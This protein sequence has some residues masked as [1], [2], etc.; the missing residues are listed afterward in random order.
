MDATKHHDAL[1][2]S[3]DLVNFADML[4]TLCCVNGSPDFA[5]TYDQ[6]F[7]VFN[8]IKQKAKAIQA[9]LN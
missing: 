7:S 8:T 6:L 2:Q 3:T 5:L 1:Q 9:S 4:E